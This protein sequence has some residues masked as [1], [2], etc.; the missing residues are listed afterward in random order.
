MNSDEMLET[1]KN[2]RINIHIFLDCFNFSNISFNKVMRF[3]LTH[4][5]IVPSCMRNKNQKSTK[6]P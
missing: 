2:G 3:F 1:K 5:S 4:Q 6:V